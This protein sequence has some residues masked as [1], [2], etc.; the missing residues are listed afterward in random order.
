MVKLLNGKLLAKSV[1]AAVASRVTQITKS[2]LK[3]PGLG[4]VLVGTDPASQ[5][6]VASK[7]RLAG[8]C[9][10]HTVQIT[11]PEDS[12]QEK[13][14]AAIETLNSD[15]TI[16][17]ILLQLP[18][19]KHLDS[20]P[21]ISLIRP[22][23]DADGLHAYSQGALARGEYGKLNTPV[24]CTPRGCLML[25]DLAFSEGDADSIPES[26]DLS[27]KTVVVVGR[28]TLVGRP[29]GFLLLDR[30]ATV[31][32]AHSRT[33]N[34]QSVTAAADIVIAAVGKPKLLTSEW[35]KEGAV[36]IDVGINR[37]PSGELV[38]DVDFAAVSSRCAAITPVPGGVGPMTVS[39][40]IQNTLQLYEGRQ[41]GNS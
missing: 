39:M 14:A 32:I 23:K 3:P 26:V 20:T 1:R 5:A 8:R 4:V 35:I 18:L 24:P 2:G 36:V 31:T 33:P 17:G 6:Y 28:S 13:V 21:L 25:L 30:N 41:K 40:L 9:G 16:D 12:T 22:D 19:P 34:I 10:F 27:G 7:E 29:L 11:L 38:G 15:D 37:L